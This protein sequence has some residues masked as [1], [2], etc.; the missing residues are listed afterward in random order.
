MRRPSPP[1]LRSGVVL[2]AVVLIGLQFAI[3]RRNGPAHTTKTTDLSQLLTRAETKPDSIERVVFDPSALR[4]TATLVGGD[5]LRA[6]YPSDESALK[7]QNLL[8]RQ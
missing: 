3:T 1:L 6:N 7:L 2:I 8:E 4:V 5:A